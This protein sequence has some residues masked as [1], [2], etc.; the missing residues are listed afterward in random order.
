LTKNVKKYNLE[1]GAT[2][3]EK[4]DYQLE[5]NKKATKCN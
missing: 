1:E 5:W 4:I 2:D 3:K